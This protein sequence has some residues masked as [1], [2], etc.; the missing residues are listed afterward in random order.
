MSAI[1]A[2]ILSECKEK[3]LTLKADLLNQIH[4]QRGRL[5]NREISGDEGD[6]SMH[7]FD[8]S[9]ILI[10]NHHLNHRLLEIQQALARLETGTFGICEE[11]HEPIEIKRLLALPWTRLCVEGAEIREGKGG[12][13]TS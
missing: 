3:L 5:A 9:Q 1:S 7:A 8:E 12:R 2:A 13:R 4:Y 10:H 6:L 11:T